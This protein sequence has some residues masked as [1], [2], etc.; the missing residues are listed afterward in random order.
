MG[1]A[2]RRRVQ[3]V[4]GGRHP[5]RAEQ[6]DLHGRVQRRVEADR[7]RRV[8]DRLAGGQQLLAGGVEA[9]AV[10]AHVA[11]HD[12]HPAVHLGVEVGAELGAEPVEAV[13]LEDLAAHPVGRAAPPGRTSRP[14][15][16]R[17]SP[18]DRSA[19]AVPRKPVAPVMAMRRPRG[20]TQ[21][22]CREKTR[23]TQRRRRGCCHR[24]ACHLGTFPSTHP[25]PPR[26]RAGLH[27]A[28]LLST[29]W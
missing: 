29:I 13:V 20:L 21:H 8:D 9:E 6:V 19:R 17:D 2:T 11:G 26:S 10:D 27:G 3:P 22:Q 25:S 4:E 23:Y 18:Q 16:S 5:D 15:R 14:P 7:R 12:Q 28:C 24:M 1:R